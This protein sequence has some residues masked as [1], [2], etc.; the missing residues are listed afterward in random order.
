MN[1]ISWALLRTPLEIVNFYSA[2]AHFSLKYESMNGDFITGGCLRLNE[3]NNVE[4]DTQPLLD[5]AFFVARHVDGWMVHVSSRQSTY[6]SLV[7]KVKR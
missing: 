1:S 3:E 5:N 2:H 6:K 7:N 4:M